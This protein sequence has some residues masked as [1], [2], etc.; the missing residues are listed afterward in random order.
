MQLAPNFSLAEFVASQTA[1]RRGINNSL[2]P[3]LLENAK[4]SAA[5][6]QRI[7]DH[8]SQLAGRDI[9][10]NVSSGYRCPALNIAIGSA[11]TSDH[12]QAHAWDW[13][14]PAFGTPTQICTALAPEVGTLGIGQLINEFPESGGWV[15]TS[16]KMVSRAVN[17]I[18]TIKR[19]G[20]FVG[21]VP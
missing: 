12:S 19:S 15:H 1:A 11:P 13:S 21:I 2:P 14:A 16:A 6:M 8:L 5:M 18:I 10:I 7:R 9:P 4:A 17:R 3:E 20:T